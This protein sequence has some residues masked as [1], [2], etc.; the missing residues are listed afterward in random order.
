M[1]RGSIAP[2][3]G[4]RVTGAQSD[5][6]MRFAFKTAQ[7]ETLGPR[8]LRSSVRQDYGEPRWAPRPRCS[9]RTS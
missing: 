2:R 8:R 6:I 4:C 7:A 9:L 3:A 5:A 1:H